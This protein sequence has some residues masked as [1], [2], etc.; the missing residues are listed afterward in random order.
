MRLGVAGCHGPLPSEV[1]TQRE[2][3]SHNSVLP[4][5]DIHRILAAQLFTDFPV[6]VH[7][8]SPASAKGGGPECRS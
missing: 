2:R 6:V 1:Q 8:V 5:L 7:T 4:S 3:L